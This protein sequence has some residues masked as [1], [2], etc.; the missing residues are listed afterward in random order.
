MKTTDQPTKQ[1]PAVR[2]QGKGATNPFQLLQQKTAGNPFQLLAERELPQPRFNPLQL[3]KQHRNTVQEKAVAL[4]GS[5][6]VLQAVWERQ[7]GSRWYY[8]NLEETGGIK[9]YYNEKTDR[10]AFDVDPDSPYAGQ[11]AGLKASSYTWEEWMEIWQSKHWSDT[12]IQVPE[13][14]RTQ[15][16]DDSGSDD[17]D[18]D[19]SN[20]P[21]TP[22]EIIY[23]TDNPKICEQMVTLWAKN[24]GDLRL[25]YNVKVG[26]IWYVSKEGETLSQFHKEAIE[27]PKIQAKD[28]FDMVEKLN[29]LYGKEVV[30]PQYNRLNVDDLSRDLSGMASGT[31]MHISLRKRPILSGGHA[32]GVARLRDTYYVFDPNMG[33]YS[34]AGAARLA[35]VL[36]LNF[37][38]GGDGVFSGNWAE[39]HYSYTVTTPNIM[40]KLPG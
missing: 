39:Y 16:V 25:F 1:A 35:E 2:H 26:Q 14:K 38:K 19:T 30:E 21:F 33:M 11:L 12:D 7:E 22:D 17:D 9:W 13:D 28:E 4:H 6:A 37:S 27:L 34:I 18:E 20:Y 8:N 5:G 24:K 3:L 23:K 29:S 15:A 40:D 32:I 36:K 10:M 31:M